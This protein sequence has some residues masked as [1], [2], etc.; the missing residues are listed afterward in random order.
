MT[1]TKTTSKQS[2]KSKSPKKQVSWQDRARDFPVELFHTTVGPIAGKVDKA[3]G[4]GAQ[5]RVRLWAPAVAQVTLVANDSVTVQQRVTFQPLALVDT[6]LDLSVAAPFGRS[7]MPE[8]LLA[9]YERYFERFVAG[10]YQLTRVVE[11]TGS[12]RVQETGLEPAAELAPVQETPVQETASQPPTE[13]VPETLVQ[14]LA[15]TD[16]GLLAAIDEGEDPYHW[17]AMAAE[18]AL[19]GVKSPRNA[20]KTVVAGIISN[21]G[22]FKIAEVAGLSEEHT[23]EVANKLLA[24]FPLLQ[25]IQKTETMDTDESVPS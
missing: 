17:M 13:L 18:I 3:P 15:Q 14:R 6:Y 8:G 21:A 16:A 11:S 5:A 23:R 10:E 1:K 20:T 9:A 25:N 19:V 22:V 12:S 2:T 4:S 7:P 24:R